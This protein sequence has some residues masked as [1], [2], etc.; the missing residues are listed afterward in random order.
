MMS[1]C[2]VSRP[3]TTKKKEKKKTTQNLNGNLIAN[4]MTVCGEYTQY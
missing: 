1:P 2:P 4:S 3:V